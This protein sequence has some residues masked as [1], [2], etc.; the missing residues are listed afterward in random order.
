MLIISINGGNKIVDKKEEVKKA[1]GRLG[2]P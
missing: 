1:C 2:V